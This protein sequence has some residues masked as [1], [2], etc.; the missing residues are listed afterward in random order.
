MS[1]Y[2]APE[3]VADRAA[4]YVEAGLWNTRTLADG[5]E[6]AA[7]KM[8]NKLAVVDNEQ[9]LTYAE[10]G[11]R[12]GLAVEGLR[13]LGVTTGDAVVL[14]AGNTL[15]S[16]VAY[17]ALL[18]TGTRV[19]VLDRRCGPADV[20][21]ALGLLSR[22]GRVVVPA[23]ERERLVGGTEAD[24]TV[25]TVEALAAWQRD[26]PD[27][28]TASAVLLKEP[29][30]DA[31]AVMLFTSGTTSRPKG[32][33]H[34][35]NTLTAG[36]DNMARITGV[37]ETSSLFLVSPLTSI[38]GIMQV[39]L[40]ADRHA[41]LILED[42]FEPDHSLDRINELGATALGGAPVIA[43]R[44]LQAAQ[45]RNTG[46][47][48][49]TVALGGAMLPRPLLELA[50]DV[51]GIEI[52]R[53]YGSSEA[54]NFSGSVPIDD[55]NR[56]LTDD[57]QLMPGNVVR[58]GSVDHAQEGLLRGPCLFLGYV[59][60]EHNAA[61]FV[62]GWFRTGDL[63]DEHEGRITVVGR[64]KEIVNRN[65]L[66][67]SLHRRR[68]SRRP[69]TAPAACAS[70]S[71]RRA[72]RTARRCRQSPFRRR[73]RRCCRRRRRTRH[74]STRPGR[75][76]PPAVPAARGTRCQTARAP[77]TRAARAPAS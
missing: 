24:V 77:P 23:K 26:N 15:P 69:P 22:R 43:E 16:V 6:A 52:A 33:I 11:N 51:F 9:S 13:Q 42:R 29:D 41:C 21:D 12:V 67:I 34:S 14:V 31:P 30:R 35:L 19:L 61:A 64:I 3:L 66:K 72:G 76:R 59:D 73:R 62:D 60:P 55:R 71:R 75:R 8:P 58:V 27:G 36:A 2:S 28:T 56:R 4:R 65:G 20:R 70:G 47:A 44:L 10:L 32:V 50:T 38:A 57:G 53:V 54:P 46:I 48:L 37:D 40:A 1:N 74:E 5:I 39:H 49:K 18:R 25:L 45:R 7:R 17:H 63:V 68:A